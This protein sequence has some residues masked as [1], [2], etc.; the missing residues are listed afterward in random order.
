MKN[1]KLTLKLLKEELENMKLTQKAKGNKT[2]EVKADKSQHDV[3]GHDIKNSYINRLVMKSSMFYLWLI[4]GI[5]G[6][7]Q[8]IPFISKIVTLLSLYYGRTTV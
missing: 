8:K 5:L 4:T 1:N 6:Y 7:A 2:N 3:A